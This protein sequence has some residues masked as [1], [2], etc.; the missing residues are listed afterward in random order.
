MKCEYCGIETKYQACQECFEKQCD[1]AKDMVELLPS[2]F[3]RG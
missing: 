3:N 1:I 2:H